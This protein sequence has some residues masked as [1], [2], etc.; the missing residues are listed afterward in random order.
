MQKIGFVTSTD[1][2]RIIPK[3]IGAN[4]DKMAHELTTINS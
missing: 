2:T 1:I 3:N 4:I